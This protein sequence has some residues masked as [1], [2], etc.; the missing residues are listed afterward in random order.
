MATDDKPDSD[1]GTDAVMVYA[2]FPDEAAAAAVAEALVRAGLIAC[3]NIV[4]GLTSFFIWEGK[5][6][7]EREVAVVMKTRRALAAEVVAETR[8]RHAYDNPAVVVLP[9]VAGSADYLT[10]IAQQTGPGRAPA[11]G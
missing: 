2:T 10:W 8:R 5:L 6:E 9:I 4:P 1:G 3:A 7:R 11:G